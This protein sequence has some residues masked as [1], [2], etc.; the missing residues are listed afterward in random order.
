M[1]AFARGRSKSNKQA[2]RQAQMQRPGL[3]VICLLSVIHLALRCS[4]CAAP[5]CARSCS[6]TSAPYEL[7]TTV[8]HL[9]CGEGR[10]TPDAL[11]TAASAI[12]S[13]SFTVPTPRRLFPLCRN[14][15]LSAAS[16]ARAASSSAAR[17]ADRSWIFSSSTELSA[18]EPSSSSA[19]AAAAL[20]CRSGS[21]A[22]PCVWLIELE[23]VSE[24][25]CCSSSCSIE[26]CPNHK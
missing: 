12:I 15:A 9:L 19:A 4:S 5:A 2:S 11:A 22:S 7:T 18:V 14:C 20:G 8:S 21:D 3:P 25:G 16:S 6:L 1:A 10:R 17:C 24:A 26:G 23:L 13:S